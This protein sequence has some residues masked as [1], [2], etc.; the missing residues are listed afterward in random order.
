MGG[1][2]AT[3]QVARLVLMAARGVLDG[4]GEQSMARVQE[5]CVG[6]EVPRGAG[7]GG[8]VGLLLAASSSRVSWL[9]VLCHVCTHTDVSQAHAGLCELGIWKLVCICN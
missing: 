7:V 9:A 4:G 8:A 2:C 1:T 3:A 5:D 6:G